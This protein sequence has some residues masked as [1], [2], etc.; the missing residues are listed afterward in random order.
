MSDVRLPPALETLWG[1]RT[2]GARG[3]RAELDVDRIVRA[4]VGVANA[5]GLEAVSMARG[6]GGLGFSTMSL[7]RHV[8]NKDELYQLMWNASAFQ[9]GEWEP[10]GETWREQLV[11]W[12]LT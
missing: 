5:E 10:D 11:S 2:G 1:R 12:A 3:P 7:S 8:S 6:A 4:A 9:L